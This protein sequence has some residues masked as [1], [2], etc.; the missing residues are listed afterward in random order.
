M[1]KED[2]FKEKKLRLLLVTVIELSMRREI[3][4]W[5]PCVS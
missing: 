5:G 3:S 1:L 2:N 4:L